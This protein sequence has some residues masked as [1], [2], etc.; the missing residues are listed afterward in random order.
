MT[1]INHALT[2]SIIGFVVV[3]PFL[4]IPLALLSHFILDMLPHFGNQKDKDWIKSKWFKLVLGIDII[5]T[6]IF[7]I[8]LLILHPNNYLIAFICALI[9]TSPDLIYFKNFIRANSNKKI[10]TNLLIKFSSV[11]Q[12]YEKPIGL[13]IEITYLILSVS[14]L[15]LILNLG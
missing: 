15:R 9:A 14:I 4:A 2:G 12:W 10:K 5:L 11:I 13:I 8:T 1:A 6:I 7:G 3:N